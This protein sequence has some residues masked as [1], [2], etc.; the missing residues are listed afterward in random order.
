M[1]NWK[2]DLFNFRQNLT[3]DQL[4]ISSV[5]E[6]HLQQ[7][8][9]FSERELTHSLKES[10]SSFSYDNDVKAL[11]EGMEEELEARPLLY[12]LKD[13]YKKVER[14]NFGMLYREALSKI[15]DV[16]NKDSDEARMESIVNEL[17]LYDWVPEVKMFVVGLTTDPRD[18]QNLTSNGSKAQDVYTVVEE[19]KDGHLAFVGD[20]WFLLTDDSVKEAVLSDYIEGE[21]L[22]TLYTIEKAMT[23]SDFNGG[24][25]DFRVDENLTISLGLDG[26]VFINGEESDKQT[27]LEDL[28]NS[29]IIPM[30]KKN[31]YSVVKTVSEN[32]DKIVELDVVQEVNNLTK[33]LTELFV[34][35]Y[36]DK[37]YLYNVDKRTGS[38]F[39]EYDSVTQLI[40]DV[41]REMGYDV[42]P[43]VENKLSKELRQYRKLED[44]EMEISNK[45]KE[46]Q[47]S[48]EELE[49]ES[50]LLTESVELKE[51][52]DSLVSYKEQLM[53]NLEQ[54][55]NQKVSE[56]KKLNS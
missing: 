21:D 37:L 17:A 56:R 51:A 30:M 44:K 15:L 48:L 3:L 55:K 10:L 49:A 6:G 27:T 12:D 28:F 46:V 22:A 7:F 2:F 47:E 43:F 45:L 32:L 35:N 16:I 39:F 8:D 40:E 13:L 29:P 9:K 38:S 54:V 18:K 34:F 1:K 5:V 23:L 41:Q 19:S 42:T 50:E 20:R 31:Y 53:K 52:F 36:K 4:E 33:A 11:V 14:K 24:K 26:K 25:I